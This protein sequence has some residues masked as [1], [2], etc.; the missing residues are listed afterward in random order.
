MKILLIILGL[1]QLSAPT[2]A[3]KNVYQGNGTILVFT[4]DNVYTCTTYGTL[5]GNHPVQC[6]LSFGHYYIEGRQVFCIDSAGGFEMRFDIEGDQLV[7]KKTFEYLNGSYLKESYYPAGPFLHSGAISCDSQK[8]REFYPET[9]NNLIYSIMTDPIRSKNLLWIEFV[10]THYTCRLGTDILFK[11]SYKIHD[12]KVFLSSDALDT[13]LVL[14]SANDGQ[15]LI[16]ERFLPM[17]PLC[18]LSLVDSY[19]NKYVQPVSD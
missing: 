14:I 6:L 10:E 18:K 1:L 13:V 17:A 11:G 3:L 12:E 2:F 8:Y 16:V 19:L 15:D 4:D 7:A 9:L 5:D